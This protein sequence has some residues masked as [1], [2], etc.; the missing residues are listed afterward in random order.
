MEIW[1]DV[2]GYEGIYQVSDLG[3]V[4]S[5]SRIVKNS[6]GNRKI[7][8]RILKPYISEYKSVVLAID[9]VNKNIRIHILVA[10]AFHN[11]KPCGYDLV[12]N[13]KDLNKLNNHKDNLEIVTNRVNCNQKHII[14][15][16]KY[17][18]VSWYKITNKWMSSIRVNGKRKHLG[19]FKNEIDAHLAYENELNKH[20]VK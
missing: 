3:N 4:K 17:T 6:R 9:G 20:Y 14:H 15:T 5:L 1:K 10:I 2:L 12:V 18:G 13:H 7:K 8:E 16:S 19:Y 11:H